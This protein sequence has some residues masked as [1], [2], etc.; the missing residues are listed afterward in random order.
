MM[1]I[2]CDLCK[3]SFC[4]LQ[5]RERKRSFV[6][7]PPPQSL[8]ESNGFKFS[9]ENIIQLNLKILTCGPTPLS[10]EGLV[11]ALFLLTKFRIVRV[12]R[13]GG[14]TQFAPTVLGIAVC[15]PHKGTHRANFTHRREE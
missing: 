2:A 15:S 6:T 3:L 8:F 11:L 10:R 12:L 5:S 1:S 9:A 4:K 7:T 14:R 13:I